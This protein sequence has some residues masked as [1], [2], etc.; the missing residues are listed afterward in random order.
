[1]RMIALGAIRLYQ[2][3]LSPDHGPLRFLHPNGFCRF[4]PTCSSYA[5]EAVER[6]GTGKGLWL[7]M[8]RLLRCHPWSP[9][10]IDEVPK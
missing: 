2:M 7:A 10:G 1:M 4:H 5:F 6:F 8:K 3:T 9:G